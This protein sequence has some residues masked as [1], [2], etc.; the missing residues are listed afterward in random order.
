MK[1]SKFWVV[2]FFEKFITKKS[3]RLK[4]MI[5]SFKMRYLPA[6]NVVVKWPSQRV[7]KI[8]CVMGHPVYVHR[9]QAGGGKPPPLPPSPTHPAPLTSKTGPPNVLANIW[10]LPY[11]NWSKSYLLDIF[12][13]DQRDQQ[14]S[15]RY[16]FDQ[17]FPVGYH[18]HPFWDYPLRPP[19]K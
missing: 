8:P 14:I 3:T 19:L 17:L 10:F 15:S 1:S 13:S 12:P 18:T 4:S 5:F 16:D 11:N 2:G 7:L 9:D 6:F